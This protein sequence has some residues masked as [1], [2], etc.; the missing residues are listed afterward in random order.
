[1]SQVIT[2]EN[3]SPAFCDYQQVCHVHEISYDDNLTD[4]EYIRLTHELVCKLLDQIPFEEIQYIYHTSRRDNHYDD[5]E[6]YALTTS[7]LM[8]EIGIS[9][10]NDAVSDSVDDWFDEILEVVKYF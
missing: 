5:D 6:A 3:D 2:F 9:H 10:D 4:D 7:W 1:M 8:A